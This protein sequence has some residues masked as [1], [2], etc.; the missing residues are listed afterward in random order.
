MRIDERRG[1][2]GGQPGDD[3]YVIGDQQTEESTGGETGAPAQLLQVGLSGP[4]ARSLADLSSLAEDLNFASACAAEYAS[5]V[6]TDQS[7]PVIVR[8]LWSAAAI[9]YRRAFGSGKAMLEMGQS[10]LQLDRKAVAQSVEL[11]PEQREAHSL[12][13]RL[14]NKHIAHR[15]EDTEDVRVA[16]MLAP[17]PAPPELVA[18]GLLHGRMLGPLPQVAVHLA[19]VARALAQSLEAQV[20]ERRHQLLDHLVTTVD[21]DELYA[22]VDPGQ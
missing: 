8:A 2:E 18:L 11:T 4:G 20:G 17:P 9:S 10:R 14:A 13:L 1:A 3:E 16:A 12:T 7:N 19:D 6:G 5:L 21:L 15:V 22:Q